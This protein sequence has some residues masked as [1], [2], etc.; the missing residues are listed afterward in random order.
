MRYFGVF[1]HLSLVLECCSRSFAQT[2]NFIVMATNEYQMPAIYRKLEQKLVREE[3]YRNRKISFA[4][5][6][7]ELCV[8][9]KIMDR[10]LLQELGMTGRQ[11][12]RAYRI[13]SGSF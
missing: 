13:S 6:C 5:L 11:L 4:S 2:I 3:V 9:P 1:Y 12:I 8:S 10:L 7:A